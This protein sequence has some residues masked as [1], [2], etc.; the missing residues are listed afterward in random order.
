MVKKEEK[1][2]MKKMNGD[3]SEDKALKK[4]EKGTPPKKKGKEGEK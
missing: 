4:T 3:R 1:R 2:R